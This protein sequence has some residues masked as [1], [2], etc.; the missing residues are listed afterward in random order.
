MSELAPLWAALGWVR[1]VVC[2]DVFC[3]GEGSGCVGCV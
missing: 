2:V 3:F 1:R